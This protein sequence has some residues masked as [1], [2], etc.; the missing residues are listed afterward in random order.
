MLPF[1]TTT[2]ELNQPIILTGEPSKMVVKI[3]STQS[4]RRLET[5]QD[6]PQAQQLVEEQRL[7][8]YI[9]VQQNI[10]E[11]NP[12]RAWKLWGTTEVTPANEVLAAAKDTTGQD[13]YQEM[14]EQMKQN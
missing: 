12:N 2:T 7:T 13:K 8:E 6:T 10:D 14:Q 5:G 4:L 3:D 11:N 1:K 9:V